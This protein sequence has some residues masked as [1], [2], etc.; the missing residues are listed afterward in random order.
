M[1]QTKKL[2][3]IDKCVILI[4]KTNPSPQ[5][6]P[7]DF[8]FKPLNRIPNIPESY[9][10]CVHL[11]NEPDWPEHRGKITDDDFREI[12]KNMALSNN[13]KPQKILIIGDKRYV[14]QEFIDRHITISALSADVTAL[15]SVCLCR[16]K[17]FYGNVYS[18]LANNICENAKTCKNYDKSNDGH[19]IE[20]HFRLKP[21]F[22]KIKLNC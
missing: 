4:L 9:D 6:D 18:S 8:Y 11:R 1:D 14:N 16:D 10:T 2:T 13:G 20:A 12:E 3:T 22:E 15:L 21:W 7:R 17:H 5:I 19:L